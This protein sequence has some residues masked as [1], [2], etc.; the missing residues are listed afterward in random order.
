MARESLPS[1]AD[2]MDNSEIE[3]LAMWL[4]LQVRNFFSTLPS[5]AAVR[6]EL[7]VLETLGSGSGYA[8]HSLSKFYSWLVTMEEESVPEFL[9]KWA[10][11]LNFVASPESCSQICAAVHGSYVQETYRNKASK[12]SLGGIAPLGYKVRSSRG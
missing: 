12:L 8:A 3:P 2:L 9:V 11:D 6:R 7:T 10:R 1:L 5:L 4:A